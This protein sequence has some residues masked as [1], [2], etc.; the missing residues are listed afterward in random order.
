MSK[1]EGVKLLCEIQIKQLQ[2]REERLRLEIADG[3]VQMEYLR[4]L[5]QDI[6]KIN[7]LDYVDPQKDYLDQKDGTLPPEK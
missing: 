7:V 5:L 2:A 3:R 4:M 6:Q 1:V